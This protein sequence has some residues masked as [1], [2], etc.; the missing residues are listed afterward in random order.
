[1]S[2]IL[3]VD[4]VASQQDLICRALQDA[5]YTVSHAHDGDEVIQNIELN[6]SNL[7]VLDVDMKCMNGY[8]VLWELRENERTK[9][10]PVV[11]S[12]T[13]NTDFD[14]VWSF[15]LGADAY[16]AR[17]ID[18][19]HLVSIVQQLLGTQ[20]MQPET[21]ISPKADT[22]LFFDMLDEM[23]AAEVSI[24]SPMAIADSTPS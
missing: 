11:V 20:L 9:R 18:T 8:E 10:I 23:L 1:M 15:E 13:K 2:K 19:E 24:N 6:Q 21:T 12:S 17:P 7:I 16:I 22:T 14:K 5:G 4:D 3:V